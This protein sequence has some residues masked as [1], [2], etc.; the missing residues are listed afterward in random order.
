MRFILKSFYIIVLLL[1]FL[2]E[3]SDAAINLH[4][5]EES[6]IG[7]PFFAVISSD[8]PFFKSSV[9]WLEKDIPLDILKFD[10]SYRSYAL[11]GGA[12][13]KVKASDYS[14]V[15]SVIINDGD[16]PVYK[17]V[18]VKLKERKYPE[19]RLRVAHEMVNPPKSE[20]KR[21]E[22]EAK[23]TAKARTKMTQKKL[24][25]TRALAPLE[26]LE[27]TSDYGHRRI[28]NDIPRGHHSGVDLRAAVGTRVRS[29]YPGNVILTGDHYF[30]GKSVYI[31]SGNGVVVAYMHL[32][33]IAV[34]TG[35]FV[36]AGDVI[37]RAG[38]TG[39]VTG[40]HLHLSVFLAEQ[41]I[42][43]MGLFNA[44]FPQSIRLLK[45]IP[46]IEN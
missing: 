18:D 30:A 16:V 28:Y 31:D 25:Q 11:L 5:K 1:L 14:L 39:R 24:W 19:T 38:A 26:K 12:V 34:K 27:V 29:L 10:G 7:Q 45:Q 8:K 35:A 41:S 15:F 2:N 9:K 23:L 44:D 36:Y 13:N 6:D 37:G 3:S 46:L 4:Y 43:P 21:I 17:S 40:P 33:S 42:D 22:N 32:D 20:L